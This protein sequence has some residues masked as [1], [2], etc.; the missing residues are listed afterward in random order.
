[1]IA[2]FIEATDATRFNH[3][4]F[5]VARFSEDEWLRRS[6]IA[7][8][9]DGS[10]DRLLLP[11]VCGWA[12]RHILVLDLQTGEGAIF[13]PGGLAAAD[14]RNHRILVCPM[15]EPF[16]AWLYEQ[17]LTDLNALPGMVNLGDVPT[18]MH[19]YRRPGASEQ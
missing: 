6:R 12:G 4:K 10:H 18:A 5:M 13:L 11:D 19:G 9:S 3:G 2:K 1:M 7:T 14:L 15:F 17:D 8:F 16:L